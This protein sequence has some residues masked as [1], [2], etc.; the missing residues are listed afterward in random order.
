MWPKIVCHIFNTSVEYFVMLG[1]YSKGVAKGY[2]Q[3]VAG[4]GNNQH[5]QV[6]ESKKLVYIT[7]K[8]CWIIPC[9]F[10]VAKL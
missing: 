3:K 8:C 5:V 4:L 1:I 10:T 6:N 9:K 2:V 7:A